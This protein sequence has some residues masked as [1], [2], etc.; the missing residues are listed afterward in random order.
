MDFL[1]LLYLLFLPLNVTNGLIFLFGNNENFRVLLCCAGSRG[2]D[3]NNEDYLSKEVR[4]NNFLNLATTRKRVPK[5]TP[6]AFMT[7][8]FTYLPKRIYMVTALN[9]AF[10]LCA[11]ANRMK[12]NQK[13]WTLFIRES[14][15]FT[16]RRFVDDI[17]TY[18]LLPLQM[19]EIIITCFFFF[20]L[21]LIRQPTCQATAPY[22][23]TPENPKRTECVR[24]RLSCWPSLKTHPD[25]L[26]EIHR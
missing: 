4:S 16:W 2:T 8:W 20:F 22:Y 3:E 21:S 5:V 1:F 12:R 13:A 26:S 25:I 15:N 7:D 10:A 17:I 6:A 23:K 19:L 9:S 18:C 24:W 14:A 11:Y